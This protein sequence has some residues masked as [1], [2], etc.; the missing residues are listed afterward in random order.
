MKYITGFIKIENEYVAVKDIN[1][2]KE[3]EEDSN[4]CEIYLEGRQQPIQARVD[5]FNLAHAIHGA[6]VVRHTGI[7]EVRKTNN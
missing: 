4:L 3:S 6:K 2:F 5:L 7:V 1:L